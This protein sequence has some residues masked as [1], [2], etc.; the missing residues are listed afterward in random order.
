MH[1]IKGNLAYNCFT[2][3]TV[4][5][6]YLF[7][8]YKLDDFAWDGLSPYMAG[9]SAENTTR[10]VFADATYKQYEA[11]VGQVYMVYKF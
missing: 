8:W 7:E 9:L 11:H 3:L 6:S 4:G 5:I 2:N 10:F 1:E